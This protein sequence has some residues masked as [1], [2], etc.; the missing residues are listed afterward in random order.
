MPHSPN[1]VSVPFN[2]HKLNPND[3]EPLRVLDGVEDALGV[4]YEEVRADR[5]IVPDL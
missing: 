4:E 2:D 3:A 5:A 1:M